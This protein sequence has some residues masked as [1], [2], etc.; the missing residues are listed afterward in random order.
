M[1]YQMMGFEIRYIFRQIVNENVPFA[2]AVAR[3]ICL[4]N[5]TRKP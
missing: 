1:E 3:P 4:F 2:N 5:S